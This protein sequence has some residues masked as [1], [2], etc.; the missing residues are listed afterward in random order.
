MNE[1]KIRETLQCEYLEELIMTSELGHLAKD[2][3]KHKDEV[4]YHVN[5]LM[6][7]VVALLAEREDISEIVDSVLAR[8]HEAWVDDL[9]KVLRVD[10]RDIIRRNWFENETF[11]D[12]Y[13]RAI[14]DILST[15]KQLPDA[16]E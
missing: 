4:R 3:K 15:L 12:G 13:I 8:E 1:E 2:Q 10:G 11:R 14:S 5:R 9:Q 6:D 7:F 16:K